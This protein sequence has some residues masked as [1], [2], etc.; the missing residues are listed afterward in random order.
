MTRVM[1]LTENGLFHKARKKR[2]RMNVKYFSSIKVA[3]PM[4]SAAKKR[5]C[6]IFFCLKMEK[7]KCVPII[8]KVCA[9]RI[10]KFPV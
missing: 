4:K 2:K 7:E 1:S 9:I 6:A 8:K 10:I 3:K 5:K